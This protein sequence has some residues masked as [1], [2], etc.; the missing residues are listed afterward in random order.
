MKKIFL[1]IV[2]FISCRKNLKNKEQEEILQIN[3]SFYVVKYPSEDII[4]STNFNFELIYPSSKKIYFV[5]S[6]RTGIW[7]PDQ[8]ALLLEVENSKPDEVYIFYNRILKNNGWQILQ[9]NK[10]NKNQKII[11]FINA[12][13]IFNRNLT[14]LIEENKENMIIKMYLK[15]ATDE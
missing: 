2:F 15:K 9:T 6:E 13:D 10:I 14:I 1:I 3:P 8:F 11:N 5:H 12:Q 7:S 4:K